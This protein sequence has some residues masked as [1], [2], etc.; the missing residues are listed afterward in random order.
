MKE[1]VRSAEQQQYIDNRNA[2]WQAEQEL[3]RAV[4]RFEHLH[5]GAPARVSD[6]PDFKRACAAWTVAESA[7]DA[8]ELAL[9]SWGL[10]EIPALRTEWERAVGPTERKSV[11]NKILRYGRGLPDPETKKK[12][13]DARLQVCREVR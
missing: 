1:R 10:K 8:A 12:F 11:L 5:Q 2:F 3:S 7:M 13:R 9:V 6:D 4:S